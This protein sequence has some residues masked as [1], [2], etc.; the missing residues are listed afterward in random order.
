MDGKERMTFIQKLEN[1]W[2]HYKWHTLLGIF[3]LVIGLICIVQCAGQKEPDAMLMY[4]GRFK[5]PEEYRENSIETIMKKD[6][7]NDGEKNA[8]V[9]QI[10]I[11][12][13]E[14]DG[15]FE[16]EDKVAITNNEEFRRFYTE[17]ANGS[18][19]IYLLH[20]YLYEQAKGMGVLCPLSEALTTV[21]DFA[22]DDYGIP[23]SHLDAYEETTLNFYPDDCIICIRYERTRESDVMNADDPDYYRNNLAFFNDIIEY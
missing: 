20:P 4:A 2:Y 17:L 23:V 3:G 19:V 16:L 15:E 7:N 13:M 21:P 12:I 14:T 5:V 18:S 11:P 6:Y 22:I 1:F 9:F 10:I 8:D